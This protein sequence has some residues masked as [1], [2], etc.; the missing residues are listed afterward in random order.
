MS[1]NA[2]C[3]TDPLIVLYSLA[4]PLAGFAQI[5]RQEAS[6]A[7]DPDLESARTSMIERDETLP[8]QQRS[9]S[10]TLL[11]SYTE[12]DAA[13]GA[14]AQTPSAAPVVDRHG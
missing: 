1:V 4:I 3:I 12:V 10:T 11:G 6:T 5:P 14:P 9:H 8:A 13:A 2:P 7:E